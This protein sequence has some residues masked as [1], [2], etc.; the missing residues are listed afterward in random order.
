MV[1]SGKSGNHQASRTMPQKMDF[2]SLFLP[3][4]LSKMDGKVF[5]MGDGVGKMIEFG[6]QFPVP[7][8]ACHVFPIPLGGWSC[9]PHLIH[10]PRQ[11]WRCSCIHCLSWFLWQR[12]F[13]A[14]MQIGGFQGTKDLVNQMWNCLGHLTLSG[15]ISMCGTNDVIHTCV[16]RQ[17]GVF[18]QCQRS[19]HL[20]ALL[21]A[22]WVWICSSFQPMGNKR[23][24]GGNWPVG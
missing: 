16:R 11:S 18:T 2:G 8:C 3:L 22:I 19:N 1:C 7:F 17:W 15:I 24:G 23:F 13:L 9:W 12:R 4:V 14:F 10:N 20:N 5:H 6:W 21:I